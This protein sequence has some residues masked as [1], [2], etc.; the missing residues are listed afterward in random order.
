MVFCKVGGRGR[1]RERERK[2]ERERD[3]KR[4]RVSESSG[5]PVLFWWAYSE[6]S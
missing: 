5:D 6:P 1:K 2:K 4:E 3:E